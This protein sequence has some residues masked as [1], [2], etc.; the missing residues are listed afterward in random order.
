MRHLFPRITDPNRTPFN[1]DGSIN[2]IGATGVA[3]LMAEPDQ[4]FKA[5]GSFSD[6]SV[7]TREVTFERS[8]G[9]FSDIRVREISTE[10]GLLRIFCEISYAGRGVNKSLF[11]EMTTLTGPPVFS[12]ED[13]YESAVNGHDERKARWNARYESH[14]AKHSDLLYA[15]SDELS[16]H[17]PWTQPDP[18][19]VNYV[20]G[21]QGT[22]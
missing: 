12:G 19:I 11:A 1:K 2:S 16:I 15:Y 18:A 5:I 9:R 17:Q 7:Y 20:L 21:N 14:R 6:G 22:I 4:V 8:F 3:S 13:L 10:K